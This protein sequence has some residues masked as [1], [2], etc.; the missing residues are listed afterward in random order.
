MLELGNIQRTLN[1]WAVY[2]P[3]DKQETKST[4][5]RLNESSRFYI[6]D[7]A[8]AILNPWAVFNPWDTQES[9][10]N[11]GIDTLVKNRI[12]DEAKKALQCQANLGPDRVLHLL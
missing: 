7:A 3:W 4:D 2:S 6:N 11:M 5:D 10:Q 9:R 1:P 8:A 12:K